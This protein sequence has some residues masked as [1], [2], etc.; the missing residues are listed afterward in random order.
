MTINQSGEQN[1]PLPIDGVLYVAGVEGYAV[2]VD[3]HGGGFAD[4]PSVED[5]DIREGCFAR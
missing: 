2:P 3:K 5:T 1:T 4:T